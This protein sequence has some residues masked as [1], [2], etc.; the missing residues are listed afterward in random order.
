MVWINLALSLVYMGIWLKNDMFWIWLWSEFE[1]GDFVCCWDGP[2]LAYMHLKN[3]LSWEFMWKREGKAKTVR[4][5]I[6]KKT[7]QTF[8]IN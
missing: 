1:C 3:C 6:F 2:T 5:E 4:A 7:G 8:S